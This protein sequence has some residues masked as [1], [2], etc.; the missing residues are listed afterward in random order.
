MTAIVALILAATSIGGVHDLQRQQQTEVMRKATQVDAAR[1][2][3]YAPDP[4]AALP[5]EARKV[6]YC[7]SGLR[8][9]KNPVS[10]ASGYFQFIDSTW[11]TTTGLP[12]PASEY[13]LEIQLDAFLTLWDGGRGASHWAPSRYCWSV[14]EPWDTY[15]R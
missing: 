5:Y 4:L 15:S 7:E 11:R 6:G 3:L 13:P 9:V 14:E 2:P 10:S 8:N 1:A 12:A